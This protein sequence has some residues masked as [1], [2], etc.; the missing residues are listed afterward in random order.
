MHSYL[1]RS[2]L[3]PAAVTLALACRDEPLQPNPPDASSNA[4][5]AAA[6][7]NSWSV[8]APMPRP[9]VLH[10]VGVANNASG[11]Q[12]LFVFGGTDGEVDGFRAIDAYDPDA[13]TWTTLP[14]SQMSVDEL[15]DFSGVGKI[16][17]KLYLVGG[18]VQTGD[19]HEYIR[20]LQVYDPARN[21]WTRKAD[22][23]R[24]SSLGVSGVINGKLYVLVGEEKDCPDCGLTPSRLLFRYDPGTNTWAKL[25]WCPNFH[26]AGMAGVINGKFYVAGGFNAKDG[27]DN[28][29]DIYDPV[30]NRWSSGA[31]IPGGRGGAGAA[32]LGGK[33]YVI[34]GTSLTGEETDNVLA[35]DPGTNKW[36]TKGSLPDAREFLAAAKVTV[37]GQPRIVAVG[38]SQ[39]INASDE[40]D[41]YTP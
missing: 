32:V 12:T 18:S 19:G 6:V 11:R 26:R 24:T 5:V 35:Y 36:I 3:V 7:R 21:T 17:N 13:D 40:T 29:L 33:L 27:T 10:A 14:P 23:P 25:A 16:G 30:R 22:L 28:K 20:A 8:E 15:I 39:S 37:G 1:F 34:G 38:G 9:R 4:V 2:L 41:L 31:P